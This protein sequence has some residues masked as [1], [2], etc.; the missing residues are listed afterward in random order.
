[1]ILTC[2]FELPYKAFALDIFQLAEFSLPLCKFVSTDRHIKKHNIFIAILKLLLGTSSLLQKNI[3]CCPG[4]FLKR[5]GINEYNP[6]VYE[7]NFFAGSILPAL[8]SLCL[9]EQW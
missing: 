6:F 8:P 3:L 2:P 5:P 7:I 4:Y 9:P 1:M